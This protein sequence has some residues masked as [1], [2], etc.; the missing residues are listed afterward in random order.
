MSESDNVRFLFSAADMLAFR[1]R[2]GDGPKFNPP[3]GVVLCYQ[4]DSLRYAKRAYRGRKQS[5]FMGEFFLLKRTQDE[6]GAAGNFGI[7]A[8][9]TAVLLEELAAFGVNHFIS[10][11]IAGGIGASRSGELV[12]VESAIRDEGTSSHY[13]PP[14]T[15]VN[16]SSEL[17]AR[18]GAALTTTGQS[19]QVGTSWTT[20]APYREKIADLKRYRQQGVLTVEMEA[21]ALFA[22]GRSLGLKVCAGLVVGDTLEGDGWRLDHDVRSVQRGLR[23]LVDAAIEAI[24]SG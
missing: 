13:L 9:V 4:S 12:L 2:A 18:M 16:A 11:G 3:R 17:V 8:P 22:V 24:R 23:I 14:S 7:G 6:V 20:D 15:E 19:F 21:A 5:G 1:R 10:V